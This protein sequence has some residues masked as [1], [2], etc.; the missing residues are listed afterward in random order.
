MP[1]SRA[2][3]LEALRRNGLVKN[4]STR[5]SLEVTKNG[6][7]LNDPQAEDERRKKRLAQ[8]KQS[9]LD[10]KLALRSG[11]SSAAAMRDLNLLYK[12]LM[13][14][15]RSKKREA[16][17]NLREWKRGSPRSGSNNTKSGTRLT[18]LEVGDDG[19]DGNDGNDDDEVEEEPPIDE[20]EEVVMN[21]EAVNML[22][23][24]VVDALKVKYQ[25]DDAASA[26]AKA[27]KDE[28]TS[29]G[30]GMLAELME[31]PE[32]EE[33]VVEEEEEEDEK[34][35]PESAAVEELKECQKES[36]VKAEEESTD[37]PMAAPE[38]SPMAAEEK[39]ESEEGDEPTVTEDEVKVVADETPEPVVDAE[40]E[41]V[42]RITEKAEDEDE[43][44]EEANEEPAATEGEPVVEEPKDDLVVESPEGEA[45]EAKVEAVAVAKEEGEAKVELTAKIEEP[46]EEP[47]ESAA[48]EEDT[49]D[50]E[51]EEDVP[52]KK[53]E[54]GLKE[55]VE[56]VREELEQLE[57]TDE[58][59]PAATEEEVKKEGPI[60]PKDLDL[61]SI[62]RIRQTQRFYDTHAKE[63]IENVS[64]NAALTPHSRRDAFLAHLRN[65]QNPAN[66]AFANATDMTV[67]DLGCGA[68][69]DAL[70]FSTLGH[71]VLGIDRSSEM[72]RHAKE[73]APKA[74][75]LN[76]DMRRAN[77]LLME[78]SVDGV[79]AH[80][81][82][83]HLPRTEAAEVLRGL[84]R[85]VREGGV[86]YAS[87][88]MGEE[89]D[90]EEFEV[91]GRYEAREE[92][93][94]C[95]SRRK[96]CSYYTAEG[97]G[98]LLTESGWE[99]VETGED[100][101]RGASEYVAHSTV[102]AFATRKRE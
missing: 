50:K 4:K 19:N 48:E 55:K 39:K 79:W 80:G 56:E 28:E 83:G 15:Q 32:E 46:Q 24:H 10:A 101:R 96:L 22:P 59:A 45:A 97:V 84:R 3:E 17:T 92:E 43:P 36:I 77:G 47:K 44:A 93:G 5:L 87:L 51:T 99:L 102:F 94:R 35:A 71:H 72:L 52:V 76:A 25:T 26:L 53:E 78:E 37:A 90:T 18:S 57:I 63:Y 20:E 41:N 81:S 70:H 64:S 33:E 34:E 85:A 62:D 74:H 16:E 69:R 82:L 7:F 31:L 29:D 8:L 23:E 91:D 98:E 42:I 14:E 21:E 6:H 40:T 60:E 49:T 38:S 13:T 1:S 11:G 73:L 30:N 88:E 89:R 100:D 65:R 54:E 9:R 68:G 95:D 2:D 75:Y 67:I 86:L 66:T 12:K 58:S 27:L 61:S